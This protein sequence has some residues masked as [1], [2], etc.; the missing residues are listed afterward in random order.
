MSPTL[1]FAVPAGGGE[2]T[3]RRTAGTS[4]E[5]ALS[6]SELGRQVNSAIGRGF[7][8]PL[9]IRGEISEA[10]RWGTA[11]FVTLQ[12]GNETLSAVWWRPRGYQP[13]KGDEVLVRGRVEAY[14]RKSQ[15]QLAII[16]IEPAG[17]GAIE[18]ELRER[19]RRLE[20][21]GL[22]A[23]EHKQ[24][25]PFL[26][27]SVGLLTSE[28][29]DAWN[30][31][32]NTARRN[33][34][35]LDILA[36][37]SAVQGAQAVPQLVRGLR[38]LARGRPDLI[39]I[40]RGGGGF[41]DLL[42]FSDERLLRA[43]AACPVPVGS[44]IG[45]ER[46]RP[47]LDRAAD[48]R[49]KTPTAAAEEWIPRREHLERELESR[50]ESARICS[51]TF[52]KAARDR[53][54][55]RKKHRAFYGLLPTLEG[56]RQKTSEQLATA[57]AAAVG[58][59]ARHQGR[60]ARVRE[61][62]SEQHPAS[63]LA[64]RTAELSDLRQ[65]LNR[66]P[67]LAPLARRVTRLGERIPS[68]D[69]RLSLERGA[70]RLTQIRDRSLAAAGAALTERRGFLERSAS[71]LEAL[72]PARVLARGYSIALDSEGRAVTSAAAVVVGDSLSIRL[73]SGALGARVTQV[74]E[75]ADP[76]LSGA[77]PG[78]PSR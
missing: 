34:P 30:D 42:P 50:R 8:W 62:L 31:F 57:R 38:T 66:S 27:L 36:A 24:K 25:L 59:L 20:R 70:G 15:Y 33:F 10:N 40:T 51:E 12:D 28:G 63:R 32:L 65:R 7:P 9:W 55:E 44:A 1:P 35:N 21:E 39:V 13:Q 2:G 75:G 73:A 68:G 18:A 67:S 37:H 74:R 52:R 58:A 17:R 47:L 56:E 77:F 4:R 46:D 72:D 69:L 14:T 43:V 60:L 48:A 23:A 22:F 54:H 61:R 19:E 29:S 78:K 45:H 5:S 11:F 16:E 71:R 41:E 49:A 64:S 6:L 26:P 76:T 53:V 3:S